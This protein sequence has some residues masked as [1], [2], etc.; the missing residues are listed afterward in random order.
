[1]KGHYTQLYEKI[2]RILWYNWDPIGVNNTESIRDEYS[3]YVP[4]IVKLKMEGADAIKIANHLYQ[5]ETTSM[6]MGGCMER[7]KEIACKIVA[8]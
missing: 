4:Y 7:C 5:L 2:D 6:G 3:S 1:M 8:L